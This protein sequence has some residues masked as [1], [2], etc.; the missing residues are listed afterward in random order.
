MRTTSTVCIVLLLAACSSPESGTSDDESPVVGGCPDAPSADPFIPCVDAFEP[1]SDASFGHDALPD[2]VL[3][4]PHGAQGADASVDVVSLGCGGRIT[5]DFGDDGIV[6]GPGPDFTVFENP[7][8]VREET[9][10]E[11]AAVLVSDDGLT[12]SSFPCRTGG[13]WPAPG[14]A[15]VELVS[16]NPDNGLATDPERSGGDHFDLADL[17]L[18]AIRYVRLVDRSVEYFG[19]RTWCGPLGGFD[20]DAIA[21]VEDAP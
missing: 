16:A 7:F 17:D 3:G 5:V 8:P 4:P 20:L 19:D 12:W 21:R 15:G 2:I 11:P 6:D 14:C 13:G 18:D 10:A 9:F 1:A